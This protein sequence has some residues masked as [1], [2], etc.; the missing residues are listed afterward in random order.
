MPKDPIAYH[1]EDCPPELMAECI[2]Q[3]NALLAESRLV[4]GTAEANP[5]GYADETVYAV[6]SV[7]LRVQQERQ[8]MRRS[9]RERLKREAEPA[10][11]PGVSAAAEPVSA[12]AE[13]SASGALMLWVPDTHHRIALPSQGR[14]ILGRVDLPNLLSPDVDLT[15]DDRYNSVSRYHASVT[16]HEDGTYGISDLDSQHGTWVNGARLSSHQEVRLEVGDEVRLGN[17]LLLVAQA[18]ASWQARPRSG[19]YQYFLYSTFTGHIFALP[20]GG[21]LLLGRSDPRRGIYPDV[22][23]SQEGEAAYGVSR[24]HAVITC[25]EEGFHV[26]D[27]QSSNGTRIDGVPL[28]P[29]EP[30]LIRPGQHLWLGGLVLYLDV[31]E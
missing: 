6:R 2:R 20:C 10:P 23:L 24:R 21:E 7:C 8:G 19:S 29:H 28:T 15:F 16:G 31:M 1:C 12:P 3:A 11:E 18:P 30:A 4:G 5:Q 25:D 17:C 13:P 26:T 27:L 9:L 14:L 22:D